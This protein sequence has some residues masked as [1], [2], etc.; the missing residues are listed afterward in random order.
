MKAILLGGRRADTQFRQC[1]TCDTAHQPYPEFCRSAHHLSACR[2]L[3]AG[4]EEYHPAGCP[5]G[6]AP[7]QFRD[8]ELPGMWES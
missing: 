6:Y 4:A 2:M 7:E 5:I 8:D 3:T 1:A